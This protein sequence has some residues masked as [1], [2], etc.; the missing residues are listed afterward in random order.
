MGLFSLI[1]RRMVQ[2]VAV[3][4]GISIV[5]F[6]LLHLAPGDPARLL[7]GDRASPEALAAIRAQYGLDQTLWRQ[8]LT[9][10]LNLL[11]GDIGMS[12]RFQRPVI[13]LI[14]QFM[15]PTLF[16]TSYVI[17]LAVPPTIVLAITSARRPGGVADQVIRIVGIMGLTIPVFWLGLMMSRFLGVALGWFPV[18]GYGETFPEHLHHMFLPA[19][20]TSIWLIPV[21]TQNLRAALIDKMTADFVTAAR[22]QGANEREVFWRTILPNAILPTINLLGVMVAFMIGGA[23]IVETVYAIPGLGSLMV[24]AL[25]GRDYY[26]VQG[27]T[28]VFAFATVLITLAVDLLS[29]SIDPRIRL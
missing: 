14:G 11:H 18:S 17:V 6:F 12:L 26:V 10:L 5:T 23:I 13:A 7:A 1:V 4:L 25:L 27:L 28:L 22:A 20:S 21:L 15:W 8:Y 19:L 3:M 24:S 9:F 16:L 2:L 29:A